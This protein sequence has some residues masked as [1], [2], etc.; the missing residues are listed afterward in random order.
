LRKRV[1]GAKSEK[2]ENLMVLA[3]DLDPDPLRGRM[4]EAI[5]TRD[6]PAMLELTSPERL[7]ELEPGSIFVLSAALWEGSPDRK[8]DV[9]RIFEQALQEHPGDFALQA[10]AGYFYAEGRRWEQ[11]I[12]CRAAALSLR[13]EDVQA[14]IALAESQAA[15]GHPTRAAAT[16][17][18]VLAADTTHPEANDL[19]GNLQW[20]LGDHAGA[21]ASLS[22]SPEIAR[23]P[24][25]LCD[26]VVARFYTGTVRRE[27]IE[28]LAAAEVTYPLV[29]RVYLNALVEHP[30]PGQRN[31]E[32]VLQILRE[33]ER[34][35]AD[36][37]FPQAARVLAYVRL[38]D[39]QRA[40]E[41]FERAF[42]PGSVLFNPPMTFSFIRALAYARVGRKD[43]ARHWYRLGMV[44]WEEE[45]ADHPEAWER[46]EATQWRREAEAALAQ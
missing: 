12:T 7:K 41:V 5:A 29:L 21:L 35:L 31:P 26:L 36:F 38:G 23:D 32:F 43:E 37:L 6:L 39:F 13:P 17:R 15:L 1:H 42:T 14:R 46:S 27:E 2:A 16:L 28:R 20:T 33:R 8:Q 25:L 4:R 18:A 19:A 11:A 24:F 22:R 10:V 34:M 30:D 45:T 44:Q 3:L 40:V 9:Y